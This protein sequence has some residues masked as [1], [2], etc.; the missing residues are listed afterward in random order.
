M[1]VEERVRD[2][3]LSLLDVTEISRRVPVQHI[4]LSSKI[5]HHEVGPISFAQ[6]AK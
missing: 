4:T 3:Y 6:P 2:I 5:A 1:R